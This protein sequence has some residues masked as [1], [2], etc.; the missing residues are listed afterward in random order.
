ME[1][2]PQASSNVGVGVNHSQTPHNMNVNEFLSELDAKLAEEMA[3]IALELLYEIK[4]YDWTV[5]NP[6]NFMMICICQFAIPYYPESVELF[7]WNIKIYSK[8]GL[9][10]LVQEMTERFP[11]VSDK[12]FER[13]GALRFSICSDYG[14][15]EQVNDICGEYKDFYKRKV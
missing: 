4:L 12:N 1:Y 10:S 3:L 2:H 14:L 7:T 11:N 13:I 9:A 8:L 6:I 5:F 15:H